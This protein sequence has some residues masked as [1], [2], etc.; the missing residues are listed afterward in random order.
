MKCMS[1]SHRIHLSYHY[2]VSQIINHTASEISTGL[3]LY[4]GLRQSPVYA[5]TKSEQIRIAVI[6]C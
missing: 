3:Y 5:T 1:T 6:Y 2:P 4:N